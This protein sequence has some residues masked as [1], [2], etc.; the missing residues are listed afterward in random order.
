M[1]EPV[2]HI[3]DHIGLGGA[4]RIVHGLVR[5]TPGAWFLALRRYKQ[6]LSR[7][8]FPAQRSILPF[9]ATRL[10]YL[11]SFV[12]L[13]GR[14]RRAGI[15]HV[16]CHLT[17]AWMLGIL[18]RPL[19]PGVRFYFHEHNAAR[20]SALTYPLL[21][22]LACACGTIVAVSVTIQSEVI[23]HGIP[24][25]DVAYIPNFVDPAFTPGERGDS[26][27]L[28]PAGWQTGTF[29][30]GAALRMTDSKGWLDVVAVAE[31]LRGEPVGFLV[32][33]VGRDLGAFRKAVNAR[34]LAEKIALLGHQRDM[35]AFYR[36]LDALIFP[37]Y[38][39]AFG[40]A[41]MEAQ[42]CG[43]PVAAYAS[44]VTNEVFQP[45]SALLIPVGDRVGMAQALRELRENPAQ[46]AALREAGRRNA[47]RYSLEHCQQQLAVLYGTPALENDR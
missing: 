27:A 16:H 4:Q 18:L 45:G 19:L 11:L 10:S 30:I 29:I 36:A 15:R 47:A 5:H 24:P 31:E 3:I 33:G 22:R 37:S 8:D 25:R 38:V 42:A 13:A 40:L 35:P 26:A 39:E 20:M 6:G 2:L 44:P 43:V 46:G 14:I 23:A 32:A 41:P 1:T 7:L 12:T 28:V 17:A 9:N 34:G 21:L